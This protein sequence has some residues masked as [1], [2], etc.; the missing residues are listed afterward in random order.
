MSALHVF[1][2]FWD[3]VVTGK[4]REGTVATWRVLQYLHSNSFIPIWTLIPHDKKNIPPDGYTKTKNENSK[5]LESDPS[6]T[7]I[8]VGSSLKF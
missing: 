6:P 7:S 1:P 2:N 4:V 3:L 5:M 8:G